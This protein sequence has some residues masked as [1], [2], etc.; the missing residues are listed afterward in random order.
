MHHILLI[1]LLDLDFDHHLVVPFTI[2]TS[3][4]ASTLVALF[5]MERVKHI[6]SPLYV[7]VLGHLELTNRLMDHIIQ[8]DAVVLSLETSA[9]IKQILT[10]TPTWTLLYNF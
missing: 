1:D 3:S 6:E 5:P 10:L 9:W 7:D 2:T 8:T 4:L